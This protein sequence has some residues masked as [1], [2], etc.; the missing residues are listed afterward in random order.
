MTII[1]DT[2]KPWILVVGI[3]EDDP[4]IQFLV[5]TVPNVVIAGNPPAVRELDYD[6]LILRGSRMWSP[7]AHLNV[8]WFSDVGELPVANSTTKS[9]ASSVSMFSTEPRWGGGNHAA[10]FT[11][12]P[13]SD[14]LGIGKET[15]QLAQGLRGD[16]VA[17]RS[18]N[19]V[20]GQVQPLLRESGDQGQV[21]AGIVGRQEGPGPEVWC[22]PDR[23][24]SAAEQWTR[25][26]LRSWSDK[27]PE[28]FPTADWQADVRWMTTPERQAANALAEHNELTI[29]TIADLA[30]RTSELEE[31]YEDARN[32]ATAGLRRLILANGDA[33]V[34]AATDALKLLGF[35]VVDADAERVGQEKLEDLRVADGEWV[36]LVEV[37]GYERRNA[38]A[39]DLLQLGKAAEQFIKR[40]GAVPS[41]R[42]YLVNQSFATPPD[43][44]RRPLEGSEMIETF[45]GQSGLIIDTRDLYRLTVAVENR[46]LTAEDARALIKEATGVLDY[47]ALSSSPTVQE[48]Q[49]KSD[50]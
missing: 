36:C 50:R 4:Y 39:N 7:A 37:K 19:R 21:L 17:L 45:A 47:P 2:A 44:R 14:R 30:A 20:K 16:Y 43:D 6:A 27:F 46:D 18:L 31:L 32:A 12:H 42:W 5:D 26:A 33:L 41:A 24:F 38:K 34:D 9:S 3:D 15:T 13:E 49:S 1:G 8:L 48:S 22:L 23:A 10:R 40:T 29:R 35:E 11:R 25:A 28:Q